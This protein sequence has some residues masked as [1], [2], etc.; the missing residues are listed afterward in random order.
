MVTQANGNGTVDVP[1]SEHVVDDVANAYARNTQWDSGSM[2][3][4]SLTPTI[5]RQGHAEAP[6][7]DPAPAAGEPTTWAD[8]GDLILA[9]HFGLDET[10]LSEF[11][12]RDEFA[13]AVSILD[14]Q[15]QRAT[16]AATPTPAASEDSPA[17]EEDQTPWY[18]K[19][20]R[21]NLDY[22]KRS[23]EDGQPIYDPATLAIIERTSQQEAF[24]QQL[25]LERQEQEVRAFAGEFHDVLDSLD[26]DY[27][28]LSLVD[29]KP[30]NVGKAES[31]RREQIADAITKIAPIAMQEAQILGI[32]PPTVRDLIERAYRSVERTSAQR[33]AAQATPVAARAN[34]VAQQ[35]VRSL[36]P[37]ALRDPVPTEEFS[38]EYG[39]EL[40]GANGQPLHGAA[41]RSRQQALLDQSNRRRSAGTARAL[42]PAREEVDTKNLTRQQRANMSP[43]VAES[44]QR[45]RESMGLR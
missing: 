23:D 32:A 35:P 17:P 29:G 31:L 39:E 10:D 20:G 2:G 45:M 44:Y 18:T 12:S 3:I 8:Q 25:M 27:F 42:P 38:D 26:P 37:R 14:R 15:R 36:A 4:D 1:A 33:P 43:E 6:A 7:G 40:R 28:G 34:P 13:R 5:D 22:Y 16:P 41:L 11:T 30:V 19:D 9:R 21:L 24:I